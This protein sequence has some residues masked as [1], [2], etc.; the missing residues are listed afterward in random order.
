M[1]A[2]IKT[3]IR[4]SLLYSLGNVGIA[5]AGY[6]L[7]P[8]Y[9]HYL[10]PADYGQLALLEVC[11]QFVMS[12]FGLGFMS[13]FLRW[14]SLDENRAIRKEIFFT[15]F[16]FLSLFLG[17]LLIPLWHLNP[18]LALWIFDDPNRGELFH[19]SELDGI[20]RIL[21]TIPLIVL[22][23]EKRALLYA[24]T[25]AVRFTLSLCLNIY[26]VAKLHLGV[27]GILLA[28]AISSFALLLVVLYVTRK[29]FKAK[30]LGATTIE[31]LRVGLPL[32]P[33]AVSSLIL[34][35]G[36]RYLLEHMATL[37]EV[38]L[39]SLGNKIVSILTVLFINPLNLGLI[40]IIYENIDKEDGR[41]FLSQILSYLA[42]VLGF[43]ILA[44]SVLRGEF[45][46]FYVRNDQYWGASDVVPLLAAAILFEAL[47]QII[48]RPCLVYEK[49]TVYFSTVSLFVAIFYF[50]ANSLLIPQFGTIGAA[51]AS[52]SSY[53]LLSLLTFTLAKKYFF[54]PYVLKRLGKIVAVILMLYMGTMFNIENIWLS[55][56][57]KIAMLISYPFAL[58]LIRFYEVIELQQIRASVRKWKNKAAGLLVSY[59]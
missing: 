6:I 22:R 58:Y 27:K 25:I 18:R 5:F 31:M 48:F 55:M 36:N 40:P 17:L 39:Y 8:L 50:A 33:S 23:V 20:M 54:I 11:I 1:L 13:T 24:L 57:Y 42:V 49:R 26:F 44:L 53:V 45:I 10:T 46:R 3:L 37:S 16:V 51:V 41:R 19:I 12:A 47:S 9:T 34:A 59:K 32:V 14:F 7:I 4:Q 28:Q 29:S 38:G 52:L 35:V 21:F 30:F 2:K 56:G 15:V 43:A